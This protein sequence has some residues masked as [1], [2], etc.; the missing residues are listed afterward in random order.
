[1]GIKDILER[2]IVKVKRNMT[3]TIVKTL[4]LKV[5]TTKKAIISVRV[6]RKK[7]G[8]W[9]DFGVISR[10]EVDRAKIQK[11]VK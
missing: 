5:K 8:E 3:L 4:N 9:E 11:V 2:I 6:F 1:M 7:T 10:P